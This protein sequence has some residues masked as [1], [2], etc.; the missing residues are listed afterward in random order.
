MSIESLRALQKRVR[1]CTE[2]DR[3]LDAEIMFDLFANPCGVSKVDGK[4][5]GYLWPEDDPSWSFAHRFPGKDRAWFKT[6]RGTSDRETLLIERDGALV[7]VNHL[8]IP[9]LTSYPDGLGACVGL[10]H[11]TLP[12][13]KWYRYPLG[14]FRI[15]PPELDEWADGYTAKPLANDC[16]TFIDAI[17]SAK[18]SKL[19]AEQE[20]IER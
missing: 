15:R 2:A 17:I 4:P 9:A 14:V 8:R 12:G 1:D 10:M 6:T 19:E 20:R 3:E 5:I 7:L 18:I 13:A 11:A 16:L